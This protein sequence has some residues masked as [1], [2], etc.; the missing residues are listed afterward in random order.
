MAKKTFRVDIPKRADD[1]SLAPSKPLLNVAESWTPQGA[2]YERPM[3]TVSRVA[4]SLI[5]SEGRP[6]TAAGLAEKIKKLIPSGEFLRADVEQELTQAERDQLAQNWPEAVAGASSP[7]WILAMGQSNMARSNFGVADFDMEV[8]PRV[9]IVADRPGGSTARLETWDPRGPS[10]ALSN[11]GFTPSTSPAF[12]LAKKLAEETG[13][14][15]RVSLIAQGGQT[16][17][18]MS[19]GGA[20]W[21]R[22]VKHIADVSILKFDI[23]VLLQGEAEETSSDAVHLARLS[24]W[25]D[26]LRGLA[27]IR[28][29][30]P[31]VLA[32]V[33]NQ[34]ENANRRMAEFAAGDSF[35]RFAG[36]SKNLE[37][38]ADGI[39]FTNNSVVEIGREIFYPA[40]FDSGV[41]VSQEGSTNSNISRATVTTGG[42]YLT[43]P[44]SLE[45]EIAGLSGVS[46]SARYRPDYKSR[47][48]GVNHGSNGTLFRIGDQFGIVQINVVQ[49]WVWVGDYSEDRLVINVPREFVDS[50]RT[51][52]LSV[53]WDG[54]AGTLKVF[55]DGVKLGE[56]LSALTGAIPAITGSSF[57]AGH[58]AATIR[59]G[60]VLKWAKFDGFAQTEDQ[61]S[62]ISQGLPDSTAALAAYEFTT[63]PSRLLF[64]T[65]GTLPA[66]NGHDATWVGAG[67]Y[68]RDAE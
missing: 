37:M 63:P 2:D 56:D 36:Q 54:V 3:A 50:G 39:H 59:N 7:L 60:S 30:T 6:I 51:G 53:A 22:L 8:D 15:V 44:S 11:A 38:N 1:V 5:D 47:Q 66:G 61:L 27:Q 28:E 62:V 14:E 23:V 67:A 64:D 10:Q 43:L 4:G 35:V 55:L 20:G 34:F 13:R 29:T 40:L 45:D 19:D 58:S 65:S 68:F 49:W 12:H 57:L 46:F 17:T 32:G 24:T 31:I 9:Q 26:D 16:L 42:Q 25:V 48:D 18:W 41:E 21:D 52:Q 33:N